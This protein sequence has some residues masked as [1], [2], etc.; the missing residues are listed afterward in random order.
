MSHIAE[1]KTDIKLNLGMR[2]SSLSLNVLYKTIKILAEEMKADITN[3]IE[4]STVRKEMCMFSLRGKG[5]ERGIG[6]NIGLGGEIHFTYY[7]EYKEIAED[8]RKSFE[9][10]YKAV[11]L[12]FALKELNYGVD[13]VKEKRDEIILSAEV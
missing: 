7:G 12:S 1:Y 6:I 10:K 5:F 8:I 2:N 9:Q 4:T 11:A 3:Y 13:V